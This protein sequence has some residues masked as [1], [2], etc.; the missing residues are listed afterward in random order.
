MDTVS[1][2]GERISVEQRR[3]ISQRY[4]RVT[5]AI[6]T[7]FWGIDSETADSHYVGS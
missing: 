3:L 7:E 5:H 4:K 1:K 2:G 6:N